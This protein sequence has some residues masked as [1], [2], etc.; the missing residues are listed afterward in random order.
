MAYEQSSVRN[1]TFSSQPPA[2][3]FSVAC[4]PV[5]KLISPVPAADSGLPRRIGSPKRSRQRRVV[6]E[7][8]RRGGRRKR[9]WNWLICGCSEWPRPVSLVQFQRLRVRIRTTMNARRQVIQRLKSVAWTGIA[10][11]FARLFSFGLFVFAARSMSQED[12]A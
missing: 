1:V 12:N 5:G 7:L 10:V 9:R 3:A 8:I 2:S 6:L 11:L 4:G